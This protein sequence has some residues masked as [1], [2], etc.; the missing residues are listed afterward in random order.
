M[1]PNALTDYVAI[2]KAL[3]ARRIA[4]GLSVAE[5]ADRL[6]VTPNTVYRREGGTMIPR[7][8]DLAGWYR[9]LG[10]VVTVAPVEPEVTCRVTSQEDTPS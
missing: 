3:I 8:D 6:S 1:K 4:L 9:A 5:L 7:A 2:R 10:M